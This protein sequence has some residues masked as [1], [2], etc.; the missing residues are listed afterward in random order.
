MGE[1]FTPYEVGLEKLQQELGDQP[2]R[3]QAF[4]DH[5]DRLCEN[6]EFA[7][8]HGDS[9]TY[10]ADRRRALDQ[11]NGLSVEATGKSFHEVSGLSPEEPVLTGPPRRA[12]PLVTLLRNLLVILALAALVWFF[13]LPRLSSSFPRLSCV[14]PLI[15][16][17]S[18]ALILLFGF[19]LLWRSFLHSASIRYGGQLGS[20][21][22]TL[23]IR[24]IAMRI[25]ILHPWGLPNWL[26]YALCV[27]LA[28]AVV[29]L[30]LS[31][32]SPFPPP[33]QPPPVVYTL[34]VDSLE[35]EGAMTLR[36]GDSVELGVGERVAVRAETLG[37]TGRACTWA[38]L[39]GSLL[40]AA[41]CA[42]VYRAPLNPTQ[43]VL[44]V[45]VEPLCGTQRGCAN[46]HITVRSP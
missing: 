40:P 30:G 9:P 34:A 32:L 27:A 23:S 10:I 21:A 6:L 19:H 45:N 35:S 28:A 38:A 17:L 5:K 18:L 36:P 4:F 11:L 3:M 1:A 20:K 13:L 22:V 33:P 8:R 37:R 7:R 42:T 26:V 15:S 31:P 12:P 24:D 2:E 46:L 43:D 39:H 14:F 16:S 41:G 44:T 25:D 29:V